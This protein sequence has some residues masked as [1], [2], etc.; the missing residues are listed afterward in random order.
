MKKTEEKSLTVQFAEMLAE[1]PNELAQERDGRYADDLTETQDFTE[2]STG[3]VVAMIKE[4]ESGVIYRVT[5]KP[6]D[7]QP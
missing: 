5:I 7:V 2:R 4:L 1:S 6:E 3:T